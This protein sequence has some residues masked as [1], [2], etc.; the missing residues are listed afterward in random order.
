MSGDGSAS[1]E[2]FSEEAATRSI[3]AVEGQVQKGRKNSVV[4][5]VYWIRRFMKASLLVVF[6]WVDGIFL[7]VMT[8]FE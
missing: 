2:A 7:R 1:R 4:R 3:R 8:L 5:K 6:G